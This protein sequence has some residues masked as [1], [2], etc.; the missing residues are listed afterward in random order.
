M[1]LIKA[2]K[3]HTMYIENLEESEELFVVALTKH[4]LIAFEKSKFRDIHWLLKRRS[5]GWVRLSKIHA[6]IWVNV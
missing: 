3:L 2:N 5:F 4:E 1:F 6:F